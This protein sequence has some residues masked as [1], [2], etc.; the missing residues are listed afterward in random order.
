MDNNPIFLG[1][2][3]LLFMLGSSSSGPFIWEPPSKKYLPGGV[4]GFDQYTCV[5]IYVHILP[6]S[7]TSHA[8]KIIPP[9]KQR[10]IPNKRALHLLQKS[11]T[12]PTKEPYI[13]AKE[14][15]ISCKRVSSIQKSA[16]SPAK[17]PY[18]SCKR[19]PHLLQ[20]S[21]IDPKERIISRKGALSIIRTHSSDISGNTSCIFL[22]CLQKSPI[23]PAKEPYISRK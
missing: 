3:V 5:Y 10:V 15:Y 13:S 9:T 14:P 20:K 1:K 8:K 19:A 22:Y 2:L 16:P 17:K 11:L 7:P 18:I 12:S 21:L 6:K 23:S 4:V